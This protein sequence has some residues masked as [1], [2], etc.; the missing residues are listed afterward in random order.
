MEAILREFPYSFETERLTIRGPLPGDGSRIRNAVLESQSELEP[1][2]SWAVDVGSEDDYEARVRKAHLRFL[3]REDM[4]L[5]LLLRNQ[6]TL[7]GGSGL[8]RIEWSVPKFEI[9]Y[10]ARTRFA[11]QGFI[12]EAVDG[13]T[14]FAFKFL[15]A[16][17][18]EIRCDSQ[19]ERSI[20]IPK[21]LG[22]TQ[23]AIVRHDSRHH[24]TKQLR[25]TLVFA[26]L[27]D[28]A[29]EVN[30]DGSSD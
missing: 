20:A 22:F 13:I 29:A 11:G 26:K 6:D 18:V 24:L 28:D 5:I 1:W 4:W 17:R 10:W 8:H 12:S 21:R 23:E 2:L 14:E 7:V 9:G 25:D 16:R 15:G 3:A 30:E 19:N 27:A